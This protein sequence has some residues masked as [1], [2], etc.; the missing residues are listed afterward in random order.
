MSPR[1]LRTGRRPRWRIPTSVL[2]PSNKGW[3]NTG[4]Q[5]LCRRHRRHCCQ[6]YL[7]TPD[8]IDCPSNTA[9]LQ[10]KLRIVLLQKY[11]QESKH[12]E[13]IFDRKEIKWHNMCQRKFNK[14]G[15]KE[16]VDD[17]YFISIFFILIFSKLPIYK[18]RETNILFL[19]FNF[20][21]YIQHTTL[22][23][24]CSSVWAPVVWDCKQGYRSNHIAQD[25]RTWYIPL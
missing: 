9:Q 17:F 15:M 6:T 10:S 14:N 4:S 21:D 11:I 2:T 12:D 3:Q 24:S 1:H 22:D 16:F 8:R 7:H 25:R 20:V 18:K 19:F 5:A 13:N 23:V